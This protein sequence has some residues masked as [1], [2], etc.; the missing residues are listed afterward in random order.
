MI[1][2]KTNLDSINGL[3]VQLDNLNHQLLSTY[4]LV[5]KLE[6]NVVLEKFSRS[7]IQKRPHHG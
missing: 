7:M 4:E 2:I 3:P 5:D 6:P 1:K